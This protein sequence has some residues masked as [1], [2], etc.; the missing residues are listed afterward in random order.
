MPN[1]RMTELR[2]IPGYEDY[3]ASDTGYIYS[4]KYGE[5]PRLRKGTLNQ[6]GYFQLEVSQNR[7]R[8]MRTVHTLIALTYIGER[9]TGLTIN[10]KDGDKLNNA[11]SNLEYITFQENIRHAVANGLFT[12]AISN[13]RRRKVTIEMAEDVRKLLN[14]MTYGE[15]AKKHGV[16]KDT[17]WKIASNKI[18]W[19]PPKDEAL[20]A[21][22][23]QQ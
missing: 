3:F 12:T 2:P 16:G 10:H 7:V 15:L 21:P 18:S 17:I 22:A 13:Q 6:S 14:T 8:K 9:P 5:T 20:S 19:L 4:T 1:E 23:P 11:P